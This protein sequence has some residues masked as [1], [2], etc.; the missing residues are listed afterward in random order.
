MT[1]IDRVAGPNTFYAQPNY[2]YNSALGYLTIIDN[3][4]ISQ[5]SAII[6]TTRLSSRFKAAVRISAEAIVRE[7]ELMVTN[8]LK[9]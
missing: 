2:T 1:A 9:I 5:G 4:K 8:A 7:E 3:E 6:C